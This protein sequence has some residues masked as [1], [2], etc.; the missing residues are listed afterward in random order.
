MSRL[1]RIDFAGRRGDFGQ[2]AR[3]KVAGRTNFCSDT[4]LVLQRHGAGHRGSL[5]S[6]GTA[7]RSGRT[8]TLFLDVE[9]GAG[10]FPILGSTHKGCFHWIRV[11][12]FKFLAEI[13]SAAKNEIKISLLPD[14]PVLRTQRCINFG[15]SD[16]RVQTRRWM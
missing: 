15:S 10:P 7:K 2:P 8:R 5:G 6:D 9:H 14:G 11:D 4:D 1:R 12:V 13:T 16:S 3:E